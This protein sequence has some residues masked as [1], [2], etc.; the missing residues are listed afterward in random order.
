MCAV[1]GF[2]AYELLYGGNRMDILMKNFRTYIANALQRLADWIKPQ[3][4]GGPGA[5]Q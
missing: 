4:G 1:V 3:G 5:P 2:V